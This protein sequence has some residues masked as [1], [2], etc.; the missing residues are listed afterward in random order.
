M[1]DVVLGE[2]T[3][4]GGVA[5][6]PPARVGDRRGGVAVGAQIRALG[7]GVVSL[8]AQTALRMLLCDAGLCVAAAAGPE[9]AGRAE[10]AARWAA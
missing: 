6:G 9:T 10:T 5:D 8:Q 3:Q 4:A 2:L 1:R 7:N